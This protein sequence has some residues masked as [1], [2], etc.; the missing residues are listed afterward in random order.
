L[1][2]AIDMLQPCDTDPPPDPQAHYTVADFVHSSNNLM[3]RDDR[4]PA[5]LEIPLDYVKIGA[6]DSAHAYFHP[7]LA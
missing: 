6:A 7:N 5:R 2:G 1:A 4:H 3:A